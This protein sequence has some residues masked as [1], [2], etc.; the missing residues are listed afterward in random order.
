MRNEGLLSQNDGKMMGNALRGRALF[1]YNPDVMEKEEKYSF[2]PVLCFE[3]KS[4]SRKEE[5]DGDFGSHTFAA[6]QAYQRANLLQSTN[7]VVGP[8]TWAS[9]GM[10]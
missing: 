7:G 3:S 6:V 8:E 5:R 2:T 10:C 4:A 1:V 9:L